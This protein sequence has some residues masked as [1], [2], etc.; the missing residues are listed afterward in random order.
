MFVC[1]NK[2]KYD[3]YHE[4]FVC[5]NTWT[6]FGEYETTKLRNYVKYKY[7]QH[8]DMLICGYADMLIC[9]YADM[10]ICGCAERGYASMRVRVF[11]DMSA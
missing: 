6:W 10:R 9:G 3:G 2:T 1:E 7:E 8:A 11:D 4:V 5:E